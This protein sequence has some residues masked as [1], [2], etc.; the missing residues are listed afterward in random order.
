MNAFI[1]YCCST[2]PGVETHSHSPLHLLLNVTACMFP[3]WIVPELALWPLTPS[4]CTRNLSSVNEKTRQQMRETQGLVDSLVA[5]VKASLEENK[6]EDKVRQEEMQLNLNCCFCSTQVMCIHLSLSMCIRR[7]LKMQCVSWGTSPTSSTV[8]YLHLFR[9]AWKD[10]P[11][12][13][14]Q[15]RV[16]PLAA[17]HLRAKKL[18]M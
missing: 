1:V 15:E 12:L 7:G 14:K 3:Y 8:R 16:T 5:Y 18:K 4:V 11:E 10:Q 6:A 17:L 9:C 2:V 13:R